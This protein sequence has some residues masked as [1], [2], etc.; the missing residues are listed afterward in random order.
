MHGSSL[1]FEN[2]KYQLLKERL[3]SEYPEA[4]DE[5]PSEYAGGNH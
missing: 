1:S 3:L 2:A 5:D 4:D